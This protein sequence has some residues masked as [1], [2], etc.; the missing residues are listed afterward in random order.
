DGRNQIDLQTSGLEYVI[1]LNDFGELEEVEATVAGQPI[2]ENE[3]Y[4]VVVP[5]Y[6]GTGGSGYDFKGEVI[7]GKAGLMTEAMI[8]YSKYLVET[9]GKIEDYAEERININQDKIDK[10]SIS[11]EI[12]ENEDKASVTGYVVGKLDVDET[13]IL[14]A[15]DKDE[16]D[17]TKMLA[18][19]I[20]DECEQEF[21]EEML[22]SFA[23]T[24][25]MYEGQPGLT[26]VT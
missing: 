25:G 9:E 12:K 6:I 8:D 4:T 26:S 15:D 22:V 11:E 10:R 3:T 20:P 7:T 19:E 1:H 5:D 13:V 21:S 14:L 24:L 18:V 17:A 2:D 23:G 16:Q